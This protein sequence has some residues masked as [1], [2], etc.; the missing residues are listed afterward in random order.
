MTDICKG[1]EEPTRMIGYA[2][3]WIIY[4]SHKLPRLAESRLKKGADKVIKWTNE[5]GFRISAEKTKSMFIHRR[6]RVLGRTA[7]IK[8]W[9]NNEEIEMTN[10]HRILGLIFEQRLNWKEHIKDVKARAMKKLNIIK[11]MA[12]KKWDADQQTLLRTHQMIILP[13]LRYENAAYGSA[14]PTILKTLD[15]VHHKGVRLALG[16]FAVYCKS[17]QS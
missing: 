13:K 14:S 12:H 8:I 3:D 11:S 17:S 16:T 9:I 15:P 2:D 4:T 5:N 1:I 6:N 7:R 10:H